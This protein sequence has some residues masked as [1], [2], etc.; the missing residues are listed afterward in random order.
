[1]L[2]YSMRDWPTAKSA[3]SIISCTSPMP[4]ALI[5]PF[6]SATSL[7]S[8]SSLSR[9]ALAT[10]R[11]ASPRTGAGVMRQVSKDSRAV[12]ITRS[13]SAGVVERTLAMTL[14]VVGLI[15]S[16]SAPAGSLL[17]SPPSQVPGFSAARPR[18]SR[19][20]FMILLR[21]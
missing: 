1:M 10:R 6:S 19:I 15:D 2:P 21:S 9:S 17:L 5:L 14:P 18:E 12:A 8:G 13:Y 20:C 4:S 3:M 7:P 11:M 16:I